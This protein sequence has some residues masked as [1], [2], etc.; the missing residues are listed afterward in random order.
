VLALDVSALVAG[1]SYRGEL[2]SRLRALLSELEAAAAAAVPDGSAGGAGGALL[3]IDEIHAL[4]GAGGGAGAGAGGAV[5]GLD[6]VGML[7]PAL[8][9][10]RLGCIGALR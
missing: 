7:K 2:E 6:V 8:A 4:A 10:G 3:F 9:R 1:T 5:G